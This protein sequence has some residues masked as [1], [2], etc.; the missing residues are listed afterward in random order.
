MLRVKAEY[1]CETCEFTIKF[2]QYELDKDTSSDSVNRTLENVCKIAP[3]HLKA[4]CESIVATYGVFLV[5]MLE[6]YVDAA[7]VCKELG[8]CTGLAVEE[9]V[10][11]VAIQPAQIVNFIPLESVF[12]KTEKTSSNVDIVGYDVPQDSLKCNMC[13]YVAEVVNSLLKQNKTED[14]II[15][16]FEKMCHFFKGPIKDQVSFARKK[17]N[18]N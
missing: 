8:L 16:E 13:V 14:E 15:A 12:K 4:K 18:S 3:A 1:Y 2:I 17:K 5:N 7:G 9:E 6:K 11:L 10:A